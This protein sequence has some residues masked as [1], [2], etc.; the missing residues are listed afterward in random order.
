MEEKEMTITSRFQIGS[1]SSGTLRTEDLLEA[2]ADELK[3]HTCTTA[4]DLYPVLRE[5]LDFLEDVDGNKW[6]LSDQPGGD[7]IKDEDQEEASYLVDDLQ[8]ALS[9]LCPPLVYFGAHWGDGADF[10]FWPDLEALQDEMRYAEDTDD[11]EIK[12]LPESNV[13][14]HISDHGNVTVY[15]VDEA[16]NPG[17]EIWSCA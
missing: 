3:Y 1:I 7:Y 15:T 10:G 11:E 12:Y 17:E 16:G 2:F 9:S 5:A 8:S 4:P 13:F 14:G 6:H